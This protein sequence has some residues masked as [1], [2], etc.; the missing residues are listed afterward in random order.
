MKKGVL[1]Y[2]TA[3]G[4][5][6]AAVSVDEAA[7]L[8]REEGFQFVDVRGRHEVL[9]SGKVKGALHASRGMLEFL[10]D[11]D[12]PYYGKRFS[13]SQKYIVYCAKGGRSV[14]AAQR[15]KEMGYEQ[16]CTLSGGFESWREAGQATDALD[17]E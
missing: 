8:A 1:D 10:I 6:V 15:M 3:A 5:Q 12:S 11:P 14:L 13:D 17:Q 9:K 16:T 2:M 4:E 7:R